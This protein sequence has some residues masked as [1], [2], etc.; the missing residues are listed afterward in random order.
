LK[1]GS[2]MAI[3]IHYAKVLTDLDEKRSAL[4]LQLSQIKKDIDELDRLTSAIRKIAP[5]ELLE[6]QQL[7]K[8]NTEGD[9]KLPSFSG[10]S[11]RWG[12][13]ALL[14]EYATGPM[15]YTEIADCLERGGLPDP[16]G[17]LRK[18]VS[19]VLSR[20][21]GL[22]EVENTVNSYV[23]TNFGHDI[24]TSIKKSPKFLTLHSAEEESTEGD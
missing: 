2:A 24:W 17:K 13:L 8:L 6:Q 16:S 22:Q 3:N 10:M 4:F 5:E 23:A 9:R 20:M 19:A 15:S 12:I 14:V 1:E 11:M 21:V 7:L 18:N